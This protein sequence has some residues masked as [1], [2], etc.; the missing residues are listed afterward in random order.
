MLH[1]FFFI[2]KNIKTNKRISFIPASFNEYDANDHS[3][4]KLLSLFANKK[5]Y[6]KNIKIIDNRMSK[7][8]MINNIKN[9]NIVFLLG[10]DTLK[11]ID[12]INKYNLKAVIKN[13]HK[14]IIGISA[15]AINMAEKVV[16]AKDKDDNI[17][18]LSIYD[19]LAITPLNIEP[20]CDFKNTEH[21][22]DLTDASKYSR[23]IIMNDDCF[24]IGNDDKIKYYGIYLY[25]KN[26]TITYNGRECTLECFLKEVKL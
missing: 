16:L 3:A 19:G 1:N 21:W 9:S 10:G 24:I 22:K 7:N 4:N 17:P 6:F 12:Y 5:M 8:E 2:N 26:G 23:I 13:K 15:G 18:Q 14:I 25:L 20:H 11:Q